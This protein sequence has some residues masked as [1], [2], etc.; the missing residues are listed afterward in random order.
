MDGSTKL[1]NRNSQIPRV[2]SNT[3]KPDAKKVEAFVVETMKGKRASKDE[4]RENEQ[5]KDD[6]EEDLDEGEE[7]EDFEDEWSDEGEWEEW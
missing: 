4:R 5:N 6:Q 2:T 7:E 1:P 3:L